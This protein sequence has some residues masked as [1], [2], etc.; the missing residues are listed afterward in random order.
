MEGKERVLMLLFFTV[1][2]CA[3]VYVLVCVCVCVCVWWQ[4][5]QPAHREVCTKKGCGSFFRS[6]LARLKV[7]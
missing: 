6:E 1:C 2:A 4:P 7:I 3:F 5:W